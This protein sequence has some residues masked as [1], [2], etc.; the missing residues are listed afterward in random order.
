MTIT[1]S[2]FIVLIMKQLLL[3]KSTFILN[4]HQIQ[5]KSVLI[6]MIVKINVI[7]E[8]FVLINN[9]LVNM[10]FL[11]ITVKMNVMV[12]EKKINV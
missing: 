11:D 8:V 10:D 1:I 7:Q 4:V 2:N 9:V 12:L 6:K 3:V 5:N